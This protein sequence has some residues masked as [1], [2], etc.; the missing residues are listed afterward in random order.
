M[1]GRIESK[2]NMTHVMR[3]KKLRYQ[4]NKQTNKMKIQSIQLLN[5][6]ES[7]QIDDFVLQITKNK[8]E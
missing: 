5:R 3:E 8:N 6:I 2:L 1:L 7:N 4:T